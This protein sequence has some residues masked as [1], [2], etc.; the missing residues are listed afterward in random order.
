M[1]SMVKVICDTLKDIPS[2][3]RI[4]LL[5]SDSQ[6]VQLIFPGLRSTRQ[7]RQVL[8]GVLDTFNRQL[9]D[10]SIYHVERETGEPAVIQITPIVEGQALLEH[11]D[12]ILSVLMLYS[13]LCRQLVSAVLKDLD[14]P[15][16]ALQDSAFR[17]RIAQIDRL[18]GRIPEDLQ[19]AGRRGRLRTNRTGDRPGTLRWLGGGRKAPAYWRY[20][21]LPERLQFVHSQTGQHVEAVLNCGEQF[22]TFNADSFVHFLRTSRGCEGVA[23]LFAD[24]AVRPGTL[25]ELLAEQGFLERVQD[26]AGQPAGYVLSR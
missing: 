14:L 20:L 18:E 23:L 19:Q 17:L 9:P 16:E 24:P 22:D 21:F 25:F 8:E 2:A 12:Q 7:A 11:R 10:F 13:T 3:A 4:E 15:V 26:G 6:G 5:A 1:Q